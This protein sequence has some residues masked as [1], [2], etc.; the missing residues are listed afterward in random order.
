L[1]QANML[2]RVAIGFKIRQFRKVASKTTICRLQWRTQSFFPGGRRLRQEFLSGG[3]QKIQL[4]T[5]GRLNGDLGAVAPLSGVQL[6]LQMNET[7]ILIRLLR[8]YF[9][10]NWEFGS[11][12]SKLRDIGGGFEP[13]KLPLGTPLV[14]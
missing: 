12:L 11:A 10:Q 2:S 9:P 7:R 8:M 6:N 4:K 5:E 3:F 14:G 13:P 1:F